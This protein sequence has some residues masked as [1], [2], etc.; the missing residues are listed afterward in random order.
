M[1]TLNLKAIGCSLQTDGEVLL[2]NATLIQL[3]ENGGVKLV[4]T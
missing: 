3:I 2:L 1:R 4:R